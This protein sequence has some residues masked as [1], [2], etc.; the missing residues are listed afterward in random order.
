MTPERLQWTPELVEQFW[1]GMSVTG[2]TQL[3]FSKQAGRSLV[4]AVEHLLTRQGS[5]LDYGAGDGHLIRLLCERGYRAAAYEPSAGRSENLS[6]ALQE[7]DGF[8][9]VV[10][11]SSTIDYDV[12]VMAEVIEH[13]LEQ[14]LEWTLNR[15][16]ALTKLGGLLI[17]TTPNE[18]DLELGMSY[19]PV[20]N[21]LFHR[22]QHVRSFTAESLAR[23][24]SDFGFEEI[25]THRVEFNDA[26]Y[27][28]SD[29]QWGSGD[30]KVELPWHLRELK[31]NRPTTVGAQNSLL[32]I[33]VRRD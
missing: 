7:Y 26:L 23:L 5:I 15:I 18:E 29:R 32:Y 9:G 10:G 13:I 17:M 4:I 30:D 21:L 19:C 8:L 22:W 16:A 6:K 12:V 33:G 28:P 27:V 31:A 14:E 1:S 24:V 3:S 11:P 2:L 25:V 20:S